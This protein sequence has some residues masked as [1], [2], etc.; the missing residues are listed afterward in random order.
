MPKRTTLTF[1]SEDAP[2]GQDDKLYVYYCKFTGK[3]AFTIGMCVR[4]RSPSYVLHYCRA[5]TPGFSADCDI[6]K[7][8]RRRTDG[9]RIVDEEEHTIKLYTS[10]GGVKL[11][12][13]QANWSGFPMCGC[14]SL[15]NFSIRF[16]CTCSM[17]ATGTMATLRGSTASM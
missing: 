9:A 4:L 1:T 11:I 14:S 17:P 8:P 16:P 13:R 12:K 10:D 2:Q 15:Q 3:H 7:L 6:N 5:C